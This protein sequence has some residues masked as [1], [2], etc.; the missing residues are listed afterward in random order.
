MPSSNVTRFS[1][2]KACSYGA[3]NQAGW[4]D[5]CVGGVDS[6]KKPRVGAKSAVDRRN[7]PSR[8][9]KITTSNPVTTLRTRGQAVCPTCATRWRARRDNI[10]EIAISTL[11]EN[12]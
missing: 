10:F 5:K 7:P 11:A 8:N 6:A 2:Y 3:Q 1:L 4:H 12:R 9:V